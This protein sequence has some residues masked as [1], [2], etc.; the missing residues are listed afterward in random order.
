MREL[1]FIIQGNYG[2]GW[3]DVS[4]YPCGYRQVNYVQAFKS[5]KQDLREYNIMGYA[6]RII[7]R[8]EAIVE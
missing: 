3:E 2:Q 5:C 4:Y 7:K 8:Y 6:H 1:N